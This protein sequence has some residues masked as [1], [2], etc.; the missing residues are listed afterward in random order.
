ATLGL[1]DAGSRY[2]VEVRFP[3]GELRS[4]PG[5]A[6][7][8]EIT[9]RDAGGPRF[10][11]RLASLWIAGTWLRAR[12]LRDLVSPVVVA[13]AFLAVRRRGRLRL[14]AA[15]PLFGAAYLGLAGFLLRAGAW[16][17]LLTP[18]AAAVAAAGQG[19]A[20]YRALVRARRVAGPYVLEREL[21]AGACATVWRARI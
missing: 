21:G 7:G 15:L 18:A 9:V 12:P 4:A 2:D 3:H 20:T 6:A 8:T 17:W 13:A 19:L 16:S 5:L 11:A 10:A 1:P 14:P